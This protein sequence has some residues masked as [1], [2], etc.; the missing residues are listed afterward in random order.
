MM[1]KTW[2]LTVAG[3]SVATMPGDATVRRVHSH[4]S[5]M[6]VHSNA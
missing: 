5:K 2:G 6:I 3:D 1:H 4:G